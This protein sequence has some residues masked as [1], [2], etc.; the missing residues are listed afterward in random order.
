MSLYQDKNPV[1]V[2]A[3]Q[4]TGTNRE[5]LESFTKGRIDFRDRIDG[6]TGQPY[7]ILLTSS[8]FSLRVCVK[9]QVIKGYNGNYFVCESKIYHMFYNEDYGVF[10]MCGKCFRER[11]VLERWVD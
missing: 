9:D 6:E 3:I 5:E 11:K 10:Y 8:G 4:Y 7:L 2:E 1:I